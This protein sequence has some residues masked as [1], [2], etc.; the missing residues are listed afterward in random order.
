[1][2]FK[3][4]AFGMAIGYVL[5]AK[6]GEKRFEQISQWWKDLAGSPLGK[7]T[8]EVGRQLAEGP[9]RRALSAVVERTGGHG[10]DQGQEEPERT[11]GRRQD[12]SERKHRNGS[13]RRHRNGSDDDA[14]PG[15]MS[16]LVATALERFL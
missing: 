4:I 6:A 9:G 7:R 5:G 3:R 13:E 2:A 15:R 10:Q 12:G 14:G 16:R 8:A 11:K 1:M